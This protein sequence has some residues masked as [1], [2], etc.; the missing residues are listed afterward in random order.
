MSESKDT[1]SDEIAR[2]IIQPIV[3]QAAGDD[4]KGYVYAL[5]NQLTTII[6]SN[7]IT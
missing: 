7:P 4:P 5:N 6:T 3:D 2:A 1:N